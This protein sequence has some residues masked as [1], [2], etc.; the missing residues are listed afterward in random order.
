[1]AFELPTVTQGTGPDVVLV[2]GA[3]GDRRQWD[4]VA[5]ALA[6]TYR[7]HAVSR[8]YHWPG[9]MPAA[10][11]R[12]TYELHRDDVLALMATLPDPVH[13]V[14]HSY[15]AG[16]VLLAALQAPERVRSLTLIEPAFGS[17]LPEAGAGLA[18][19][20]ASRATALAQVRELVDAERH[21]DAAVAFIDW[22]QGGAGGFSRLPEATRAALRENART[23]GPTIAGSQP[24]VSPVSLRGLRVPA[25]VVNGEQTRGY[26][27]LI[28][29]VTGA[30]IPGAKRVVVPGSGHMTI[31]EAPAETAALLQPFLAR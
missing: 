6:S 5:A 15:G 22:V 18:A 30:S 3:L 31:V 17:L 11:E 25:L 16:V 12:Y 10:G 24:D 8:R 19:E 23:L 27:R 13:L 1:M 2:H 29:E 26:Y 14:G 4:A 9:P 20:K 28:G 7:T 21:D